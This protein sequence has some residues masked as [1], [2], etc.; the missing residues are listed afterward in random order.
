MMPALTNIEYMKL[1]SNVSGLPKILDMDYKKWLYYSLLE[2]LELYGRD[3]VLDAIHN[4][5]KKYDISK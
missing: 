5:E 2:L 1:Y 4:M 3:K